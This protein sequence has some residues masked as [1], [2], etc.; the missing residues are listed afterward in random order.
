MTSILLKKKFTIITI[1]KNDE[2]NIEKTINSILSQKNHEIEYIVIDGNSSDRTME[3]I[4]KYK[5]LID[6]VISEND[7]G[8]YDAINKAIKISNGEVI[9]TC[10]SGDILHENAINNIQKVFEEKKCDAVFGT[11]KRHYL[12]A[13]VLKSGV[14]INRIYYNFD[15]ATAHSTGFYVRRSVHDQIGLYDTSFKCSADYDFFFR[16][17]KLKKFKIEATCKNKLIGE[18]SAGGF[19]STLTFLEHL[20]EETKIRIKNKQN[21]LLISIIYLNAILKNLKKIIHEKK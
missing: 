9:V 1:V 5:N 12:G 8:I 15:F 21:I 7:N 4:N 11:V 3:K 13:T 20:N 19:S 2:I 17:I 16:M 6:T 18:V 14:D 10:N